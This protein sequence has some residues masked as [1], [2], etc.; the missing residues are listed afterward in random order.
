M[1]ESSGC[2][3]II[4]I[5]LV[6]FAI[7]IKSDEWEDKRKA[8]KFQQ[9]VVQ[10]IDPIY[11]FVLNGWEEEIPFGLDVD[12]VIEPAS[13]ADSR[14]LK[15][16]PNLE[17]GKVPTV[18]NSSGPAFRFEDV[19]SETES[20]ILKKKEEGGNGSSFRFETEDSKEQ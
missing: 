15:A 10:N 11:H 1:E 9:E 7:S 8:E 13:S 6:I 4:I 12:E 17:L 2:L 18:R 16:D 5:F 19:D 14:E 3:K 20:K